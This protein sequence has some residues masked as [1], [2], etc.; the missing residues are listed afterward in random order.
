MNESRT[1]QEFLREFVEHGSEAAFQHLV[2]RHINMVFATALRRLRDAGAAQEITQNVFVALARKAAWL[3]GEVGLA[4]WLHKTAVLEARQWWRGELRRK[5]REETAVALGTTMKAED[6]LAGEASPYPFL[7]ALDEGLLE[8][9]ES[10]RQALMLRYLEGRSHREVGAQLGIGEDAARKRID[11]ALDQL[12]RFFQRR[13]YAVPAATAT[14]AA[15]RGV[16]AHGAPTGASVAITK[17]AVSASGASLGTLAIYFGKFMALTKT[18][19]ALIC[20][21]VAAAP[22]AYEWRAAAS[23]RSE[24]KSVRT[25]LAQFEDQIRQQQRTLAQVQR[26]LRSTDF[27]LGEARAMAVRA[28]STM[29]VS[30]DAPLYLWDENSDYV[31]VPK[32]MLTNLMLTAKAPDRGRITP[33]PVSIRNGT[34]SKPLAEALG[35][36]SEDEA[37][38]RESLQAFYRDYQQVEQAFTYV[39]NEPMRESLDPTESYMLVTARFPEQGEIFKQQLRVALESTLGKERTDLLWQQATG[40]LREQLNDFG[41]L[42]RR[43]SVALLLKENRVAY[44]KSGQRPGEKYPVYSWANTMPLDRTTVPD[45][46]RPI[47]DEWKSRFK[48]ENLRY[49]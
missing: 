49:E 11:K 14:A 47:V 42:E 41:A 23:A 30:P 36:T 35:M 17:A 21:A 40:E 25:Q 5:T 46:F 18:E 6:R 15:L 1:D 31:R 37:R 43:E 24:E 2:E 38:V 10:D 29:P 12:T 3:R 19:T 32:Q 34:L 48:L 33:E 39:T 26:R 4:G 7:G 13:G 20:L 45:V 27:A 9:R 16:S 8:L 44:T 22:L 28:N